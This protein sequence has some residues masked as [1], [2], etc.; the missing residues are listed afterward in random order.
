MPRIQLSRLSDSFVI[1]VAFETYPQSIQNP[2]YQAICWLVSHQYLN[3]TQAATLIEALV[4]EVIESFLLVKEG[5]Y[6]LGNDFDV[7]PEFCRLELQSI[8]EH[9]QQKLQGWRCLEPEIWSP[10]QR[11]YFSRLD[12]VQQQVLLELQHKLI[13]MLKDLSFY[14]LAALLNQNELQLAQSL[15]PYIVKRTILLYDPHSPFQQLPKTF[16]QL[17]E[18]PAHPPSSVT[19]LINSKTSPPL[20]AY[21]PASVGSKSTYTIWRR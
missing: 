13:A 17:P 5:T 7:L 6:Q 11:P 8:V 14:Q 4:K 12:R 3:P 2:D 21:P 16:E 10:Y 15:H 9:C 18:V 20:G 1:C 19:K